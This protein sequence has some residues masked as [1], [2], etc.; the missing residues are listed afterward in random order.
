MLAHYRDNRKTIRTMILV[1]TIGGCFFVLLGIITGLRAVFLTG[2]G[3]AVIPDSLILFPAMFLTLGIAFA[4]L[5]SSYYFSKFAKVWDQRLREIDESECT[6][7]ERL[8]L[9]ER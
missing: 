3:V 8:R 5:L 4:S 7:Q 9:D 2:N 6:L 1:S